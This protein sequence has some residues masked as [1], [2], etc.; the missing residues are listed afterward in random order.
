M[1]DFEQIHWGL[2][3]KNAESLELTLSQILLTRLVVIHK[4]LN[5]VFFVSSNLIVITYKETE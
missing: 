1:S 3:P 4:L 2:P 5:L